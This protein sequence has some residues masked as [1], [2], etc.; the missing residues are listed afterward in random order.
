VQ[1]IKRRTLGVPGLSVLQNTVVLDLVAED[2]VVRGALALDMEAGRFVF[3]CAKAVILA[4]GGGMSAFKHSTAPVELTGDGTAMAARAG[5]PLVDMEFPMFFPGLFAWPPA[6][7]KVE[8]PYHLS[9]GGIIHGHMYNKRGERFMEKWD[10]EHI[11]HATRDIVSVGIYNEILAGNTGKHGGVYVS[12]KHLPD[13]LIDDII[14]WDPVGSLKRYGFGKAYFDMPKYLPDLKRQSLEAVPASHFFNGGVV[15]D[16]DCR[17]GMAGVFAA[18]EVTGGVHGGNRLSG[19]AFSD[20]MVF[21]LI[22]GE[23]AAAFAMDAD[24]A[25]VHMDA[26]E[27][28]CRPYRAILDRPKGVSPFAVKSALQALAWE[29]LGVIRTQ[30]R[31]KDAIDEIRTHKAEMDAEMGVTSGSLLMNRELL[32]AIEA[33]N[34]AQNM[35]LIAVAALQRPESRAAHYLAENP[36]TDYRS[37]TKNIKLRIVEGEVT[38]TI[39]PI[40]GGILD[41]P[42]AVVPYGHTEAE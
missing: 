22:A 7:K 33:R 11:E 23:N 32:A 26:V 34:I 29:K 12:L 20:F 15:I 6:L 10:P 2:D 1:V 41:P 3:I 14:E 4:T 24:G 31:I 5:L 36:M 17:T 18:G 37:W 35:E 40:V 21:G 9:A 27:K 28:A 13:D 16:E 30:E 42:N 38:T 25:P 39:E 19:A 8:V